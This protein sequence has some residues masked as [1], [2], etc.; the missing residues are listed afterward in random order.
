MIT[1]KSLLIINS[2][3]FLLLA[4]A[5]KEANGMNSQIHFSGS[6]SENGDDV[7]SNLGKGHLWVSLVDLFQQSGQIVLFMQQGVRNHQ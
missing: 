5:G 2:F 3:T 1:N 4:S 6:D 7:S